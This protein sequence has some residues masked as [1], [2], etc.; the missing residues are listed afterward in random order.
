MIRKKNQFPL[1]VDFDNSIIKT[2]CSIEALVFNLKARFY[3]TVLF[4]IT[5][6]FN[7]FSLKK[8]LFENFIPDFDAIP[9]NNKLISFL[10][11]E[12]KLGRKIYLCSG[13]P[14]HI[15]Q[16]FVNKY[17]LFDGYYGTDK[18]NLVGRNKRDFLNELFGKNKYDYI[19]DAFSDIEIWKCSC[20]SYLASNNLFLKI[21]LRL[22]KIKYTSL[23]SDSEILKII[24]NF[25]LM[26][27]IHHWS[28]NILLFLPIF[29]A[30]DYSANSLYTCIL[31]FISFSL[32]ASSIYIINDFIDLANDRYH[33]DKKERVIASGA[34]S[35]INAIFIAISFLIASLTIAIYLNNMFSTIVLLYIFLNF[36]YSLKIKN[37]IL[38]DI[39][40]LSSFYVI[41][42][43][44]GGFASQTY[45]S[46]WLLLFCFFFFVFLANIKRIT[47]LRKINN[48]SL[49]KKVGREYKVSNLKIL[50]QLNIFS[51]FTSIM[52]L[53]VYFFY[54][55]SMMLYNKSSLSLLIIF[56]LFLW[57]LH[58][59][60]K[61][62]NGSLSSDPIVFALKDKV[63]WL[64]FLLIF[65]LTV[66][67]MQIW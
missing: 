2:D 27:R 7:K 60:K 63:S 36:A 45:T 33:P 48:N 29:L 30:Q 52:I 9:T 26:I 66:T 3:K 18:N 39:F 40:V 24:S 62:N 50:N 1:V 16:N 59:S 15:L 47:E 53:F 25:F 44:A 38:I 12:K 14:N 31:G 32:I 11:E 10:K 61:A 46:Y 5:N 37:I 64:C 28:K 20:N 51:I 19:G 41:R 8:Y 56:I 13:T 34:I 57:I 42:V 22:I 67:Q 43:I 17:K 23:F 4:F 49:L 21:Y 58:I 35:L 6:I 65:I 55:R 54:D